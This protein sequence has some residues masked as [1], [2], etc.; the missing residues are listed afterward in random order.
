MENNTSIQIGNSTISIGLFA[1]IIGVFAFLLILIAIL[2]IYFNRKYKTKNK[3]VYGFGG[4]TLYL[5]L[6]VIGVFSLLYISRGLV[7]DTVDYLKLAKEDNEVY[8]DIRTIKESEE[9]YVVS[10]IAVPVEDGKM[11]SQSN[12]TMYWSISGD[13]DF[14]FK[15]VNRNSSNISFFSTTL[16]SGK[17]KVSVI[18]EGDDF[19]VTKEQELYIGD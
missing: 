16:P 1:A 13:V 10:F 11:W 18:V 5:V 3:Q 7:I 19:L 8:L 6:T 17:Y 12:Y 9:K 2:F 14:Q 15:E 4:K